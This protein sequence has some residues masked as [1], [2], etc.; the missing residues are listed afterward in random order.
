M[1]PDAALA[2]RDEKVQEVRVEKAVRGLPYHA[3]VGVAHAGTADRSADGCSP[4]GKTNDRWDREA[5]SNAA[6][7]GEEEPAAGGLRPRR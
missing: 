5:Q 6:L 2:N 1:T 4:R 7:R 3:G